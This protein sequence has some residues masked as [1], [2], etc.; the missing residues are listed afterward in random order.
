MTKSFKKSSA[1]INKNLSFSTI[2]TKILLLQ[3]IEMRS[4]VLS[5]FL[6]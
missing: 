1:I 5:I 4:K 2:L 6:K 3:R